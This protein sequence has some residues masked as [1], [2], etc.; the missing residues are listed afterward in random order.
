MNTDETTSRRELPL[1]QLNR[2]PGTSSAEGRSHPP[3]IAGFPDACLGSSAPKS[4]LHSIGHEVRGEFRRIA[5]HVAFTFS[6]LESARQD[7]LSHAAW[8]AT[9][10]EGNSGGKHEPAY[11]TPGM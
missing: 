9:R 7:W 5:A 2:R 4:P 11:F 8:V 10:T 1:P 3:H 6:T